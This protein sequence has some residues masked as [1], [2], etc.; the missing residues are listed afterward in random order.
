MNKLDMLISL[1]HVGH[2]TSMDVMEISTDPVVFDHS[3]PKALCSHQR[4]ITDEQIQMC[5][6]KGG[7]VGLTPFSMFVSDVKRPSE[8]GVDDYIKHTDYVVNLV[9]VDHVGIG[10]DLAERHYRTAEM[11]L[12]ERRMLPGLTAKFIQEI[13]D[14][15]I[16]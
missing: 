5:A 16:K 13:E 10:L 3:N 6:E 2:K 9:G 8:L 11:I 12:E 1:S 4:N 15:F 14:D 7:V